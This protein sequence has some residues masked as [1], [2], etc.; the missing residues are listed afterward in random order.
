MYSQAPHAAP[1]TVAHSAAE[2]FS[3][4]AQDQI[5]AD[6]VDKVTKTKSIIVILP[7]KPRLFPS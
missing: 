5:I 7:G 2:V 6:K 1:H 3:L 4:D